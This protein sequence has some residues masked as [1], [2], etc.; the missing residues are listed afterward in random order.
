MTASASTHIGHAC[1]RREKGWW[2]GKANARFA[3]A[4]AL[5]MGEAGEEGRFARA[6]TRELKECRLEEDAAGQRG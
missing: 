5:Y 3:T 2:T 6:L 1:T 4:H